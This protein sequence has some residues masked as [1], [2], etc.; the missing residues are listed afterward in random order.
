MSKKRY[1]RL[2][3]ILPFFGMLFLSG[4]DWTLLNPKGQVGIDE[5]NLILLAFALMLTVV[6]P[7]IVMALLFAWR[8]RAS[9]RNATYAP[10]W[11]HSTKI[12][13][14]VWGVPLIIIAVLGYVTYVSTHHLDPYRPLDSDV[15][16]VRIQVVALDWKWLFIYPDQGIATVNKIVFPAHTPV[17]FEITSDAVMNSFFIPA[18]GGQIYAMAGMQTKLHL[19]A[20]QEGDFQGIS[21]NYSGAGFTGMSFQAQATT[22][23]AFDSWVNEVKNSPK[24]LDSAEYTALAKPSEK[25]PVA[26]YASVPPNLFHTIIDKYEGMGAGHHG[27]HEK[28]VLGQEGK[29]VS[30]N[31]AAGA[32]E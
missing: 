2:F 1:P 16:P 3:G 14:V 11:A 26:L 15:K 29:E 5:R 13:A 23:A 19:I 6:I 4:C 17:A 22:Q 28:G 10:E 9:N 12:E 24:A 25:N 31:S 27:M 21:A 8:Y 30:E 18:L 7:V 20:N 32:E